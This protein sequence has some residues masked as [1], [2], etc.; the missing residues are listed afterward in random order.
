MNRVL[1]TLVA[2]A[3][4]AFTS[5]CA[6]KNY[7]RKEMSPTVNK[8]NELDELTRKNTNDIRDLDTRA[9]K[10]IAD[11]N[12]KSDEAAQKAQVAGQKAG[13]AQTLASQAAGKADMLGNVVANLDNYHPVAEASVHFGF[14]QD[15]LTKKAKAALD[16]FAAEIPNAKS[17]IVELTG[18]TDSVGDKQYNYELSQR[19]ARAVVQYLA[20]NFDVPAHKIY[21]IGIGE[22]KTV[23]ENSSSSGRAQNRRVDLRLM[24]NAVGT[25]A[26][27]QA[28]NNQPQQR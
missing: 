4:I 1:I 7:V 2:T 6:T 27:T 13:E 25:D 10:G 24:T 12:A 21:V 8:V 16:Q 23:A 19:R 22:D 17:Y 28:S 15:K 20:Q 11:V 14:N 5:G 26:P 9:Q 18:G 3:G